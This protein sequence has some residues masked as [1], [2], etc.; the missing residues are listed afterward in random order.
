[1]FKTYKEM[2]SNWWICGTPC[3]RKLWVLQVD[4]VSRTV[5]YFNGR[6]MLELVKGEKPYFSWDGS[7]A[8]SSQGPE[9]YTGEIT[10]IFSF[11]LCPYPCEG[12]KFWSILEKEFCFRWTSCLI[13][14][15]CSLNNS[16]LF[17]WFRTF[18]QSHTLFCF[19]M[20][21]S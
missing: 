12:T 19:G 3:Q 7:W 10:Y 17:I 1:M 16:L 13:Q 6:R 2:C 8:T 21:D 9:I 18:P 11:F 15:S 14:C 20:I 5:D 4:E